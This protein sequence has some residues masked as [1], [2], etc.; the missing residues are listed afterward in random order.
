MILHKTEA[1][2]V[3]QIKDILECKWG[4]SQKGITFWCDHR[5]DWLQQLLFNTIDIPWVILLKNINTLWLGAN[6]EYT[7][8]KC[9]VKLCCHSNS[10]SSLNPTSNCHT[11]LWGWN[12]NRQHLWIKGLS[13]NYVHNF[14]RMH[15]S[16][17]PVFRD[18]FQLY[19]CFI[20]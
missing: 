20:L 12:S 6:Q 2:L 13:S 7:C 16:C 19:P 9:Y 5:D 17:I 3:R 15:C 18:A 8:Y 10:T 4:L 11:C 1:S 14:P